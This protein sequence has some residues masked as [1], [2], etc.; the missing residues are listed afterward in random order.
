MKAFEI[1]AKDTVI[2]Y[3]HGLRSH[4]RA[5]HTVLQHIVKNV[6]VSVVSLEMPGHGE[7]SIEEHCMVPRYRRIVADIKHEIKSR[8]LAT[9]QVILMGYSFGSVL[10]LLASEALDKDP[11]FEPRVA[12]F[13][14]ISTAFH[15]GHN[16]ARWKVAMVNIIA[17]LSRFLFNNFRH[18]SSFVTIG[19]MDAKLISSDLR[20][21][22]KILSDPLVYKGRIPLNTSAQVYKAGIAARK[23]LDKL[24]FPVL[25][26]HSIDDSVALPPTPEKMCSHVQ[27]RLFKKLRHNCIDG[28]ARE[29]IVSRQ[30]ITKFIT[31]RR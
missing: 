14:G 12:G 11:D 9:E 29:A 13:I 1:G 22:D 16:V 2:F 7:D 23:A 30:T 24:R 27:L 17:P 20:V 4:G 10:M 21:Q 15:V 18:A 5:Q 6:G 31:E 19:E 25:L 3:M 8:C 26:L 28:L